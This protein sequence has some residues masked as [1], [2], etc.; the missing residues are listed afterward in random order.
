MAFIGY[1]YITSEAFLKSTL[2]DFCK[3]AGYEIEVD[4]VSF[5]LVNGFTAK[6]VSLISKKEG[7]PLK[8][9]EAQE[10]LIDPDVFSFISGDMRIREISIRESVIKL[11]IPLKKKKDIVESEESNEFK[12]LPQVD[13]IKISGAEIYYEDPNIFI[14]GYIHRVS[15]VNVQG[16]VTHNDILAK[17]RFEDCF[18]GACESQIFFDEIPENNFSA[19]RLSAVFSEM[20]LIEEDLELLELCLKKEYRGHLLDWKP[21]G[22]FKASLFIE[23]PGPLAVVLEAIDGRVSCKEILPFQIDKIRGKCRIDGDNFRTENLRRLIM[24]SSP[25]IKANLYGNFVNSYGISVDIKDL[26]LDHNIRDW[27]VFPPKV[28]RVWKA[29]SLSGRADAEADLKF[30]Y[31]Y[32][33]WNTLFNVK[34]KIKNAKVVLPEVNILVNDICSDFDV[35]NDGDVEFNNLVGNVDGDILFIDKFLVEEKSIFFRVSSNP[36]R[37]SYSL[38]NPLP[39][40]VKMELFGS[41]IAGEL[42][43]DNVQVWMDTDNPK[44]GFSSSGTIH[45]PW[46]NYFNDKV[47][48][49]NGKIEIGSLELVDGKLLL[50]NAS[51]FFEEIM[52]WVLPV[53][54]SHLM[55]Y[56]NGEKGSVV[57][58]KA[59][60]AGGSVQAIIPIAVDKKDENEESGWLKIQNADLKKLMETISENSGKSAQFDVDK[61][62]G[63]LNCRMELKSDPMKVGDDPIISGQF[64]IEDGYIYKLDTFKGILGDAFSLKIPIGFNIKDGIEFPETVFTQANGIVDIYKDSIKIKSLFLESEN[65]RVSLSGSISYRQYLDIYITIIPLTGLRLPISPSN[66][67][68]YRIQGTFSSPRFKTVPNN[69][70]PNLLRSLPGA[71]WVEGFFTGSGKSK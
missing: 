14:P 24:T 46:I 7:L 1:H 30:D 52:I 35:R 62:S 17:V 2:T 41:G 31:R 66:W 54:K 16:S 12:D 42:G 48:A 9:F 8:E 67:M 49:R 25:E 40:K 34:G 65:Y 50:K 13:N 38:L 26:A 37:L 61:V 68:G 47:K 64:S 36:V 56:W 23:P 58:D 45:V 63:R 22:L 70:L 69:Y 20:N 4:T 18:F 55:L 28:S 6:S 10:V 60:L 53:K 33:E 19:L 51:A 29:L 59:E 27:E 5:D 57:L 21:G 32:N 39:E 11:S 3:K 44:K 15:D 43:L 71:D